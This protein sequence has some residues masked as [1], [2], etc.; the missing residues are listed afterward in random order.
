MPKMKGSDHRRLNK[1]CV[2]YDSLFCTEPKSVYYKLKCGGSSHCKFYAEDEKISKRIEQDNRTQEEIDAENRRKYIQKL[3]PKMQALVSSLDDRRYLPVQSLKTCYICGNKL[4]ELGKQRKQCIFCHMEYV[5]QISWLTDNQ[6][7][8]G[9]FVYV[10]GREKP[11][12]AS[13]SPNVDQCEF[14]NSN[15]ICSDKNSPLFQKQCYPTYCRKTKQMK[16]H[17][18][19]G[20][21]NIPLSSI[22][23]HNMS[24]PRQSKIDYA[25]EEIQRA[26]GVVT[27]IYVGLCSDKYLIKEGDVWYYAALQCDLS[28]IPAT[29]ERKK[30]QRN[31]FK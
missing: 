26:G 10:M 17:K 7:M 24:L 3:K 2:H 30:R 27:P 12:T 23:V 28:S 4:L 29:L 13:D 20:V 11:V 6:A 1:W 21:K 9:R 19:Q 22:T 5:D 31:D 15:G 14:C 18:F 8:D 16:V 25:V